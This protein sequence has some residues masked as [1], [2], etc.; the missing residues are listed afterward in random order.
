MPELFSSDGTIFDTRKMDVH[1]L[2]PMHKTISC[3]SKAQFMR[4]SSD[5][6][7][8]TCPECLEIEMMESGIHRD[9]M[10]KEG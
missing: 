2:V 9:E 3:D 1:Y 10:K 8:V 5:L 4:H 6:S 7:E